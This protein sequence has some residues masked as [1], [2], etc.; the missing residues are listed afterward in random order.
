MP[1]SW[2]PLLPPGSR[3]PGG[4]LPL[5]VVSHGDLRSAADSGAWLSSSIARTGYI[6]AKVNA[7]GPENG[8]AALNEI[9]QRPDDVSRAIG[10][11]LKDCEW[12][13][14]I[15]QDRISVVRFAVGATAALSAAGAESILNDTCNPA[16]PMTKQRGR[17]ADGMLRGASR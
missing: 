9:W 2:G 1:L 7:P 10:L 6:V 5:V 11:M 13:A 12:G 4:P 17:I 3:A 14:R 15:D 8:A 16:P